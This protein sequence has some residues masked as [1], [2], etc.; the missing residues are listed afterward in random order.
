M[1]KAPIYNLSEMEDPAYDLDIIEAIGKNI[2]NLRRAQK[3]TQD[4]LGPRAGISANYLGEIERGEKNATGLV[5]F[6]LAQALDA[7]IL[8]IM[9]PRDSGLIL[10]AE[11]L[12]KGKDPKEVKRAI[13]IMAC[14]LDH[15]GE[16]EDGNR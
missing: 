15:A 9:P 3:L 7:S 11:K 13:R 16:L 2:K 12:F 6:K 1:E 5:I 4:E 14:F 10:E 8:E